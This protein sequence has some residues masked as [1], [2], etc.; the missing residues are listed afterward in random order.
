MSHDYL[1]FS[2]VLDENE[3]GLIVSAEGEIK[4]IWV[5]KHLE[6][7]TDLPA[8]I[9]QMCIEYFGIDPSDTSTQHTIH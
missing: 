7:E 5:P 4:G 1:E 9:C 3:Y 8:N 2:D 6:K